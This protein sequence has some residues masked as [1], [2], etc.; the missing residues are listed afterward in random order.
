MFLYS[1][2]NKLDSL[3]I[4]SEKQSGEEK[5]NTLA[6]ISYQN[7]NIN[8]DTGLY[9]AEIALE[10][11]KL[12]KND[13]LKSKVLNYK[14]L[15]FIGKRNY[16]YSRK[17][18]KEALIFG[19][20]YENN[21]Q[22]GNSYGTLGIIY[23]I[24]NNFDSALFVFDKAQNYYIKSKSEKQLA[25]TYDNIGII[26]YL[27]GDFEKSLE[28]FWLAKNLFEKLNETILLAITYYKIGAVFSK[29]EKLTD[30][31]KYTLKSY[32]LLK[33][34]TKYAD[35]VRAL[36]TLGIISKDQKKF[37]TALNYYLDALEILKKQP[38]LYIEQSILTNIGLVYYSTK[39]YDKAIEYH[40]NSLEIA[41]K[42]GDKYNM[43]I[44]NNNIGIAL[45]DLKKYNHAEKYLLNSEKFFVEIQKKNELI[46]TYQKLYEIYK[47]QN[48]YKSAFEYIEKQSVLKDS[49]LHSQKTKSLDSLI[50]IFKTTELESENK[51]LAHE[52]ELKNKIIRIQKLFNF[53]AV[54]IVLLILFFV[55]II[56]KNKNTIKQSYQ[57]VKQKNHEITTY[58]EELKTTNE[59]LVELDQ[60]KAIT[61][62]MIVHDLKNPLNTIIN[63]FQDDILKQKHHII[64]NAG[65]KMKYMVSNILD[66][67]KYE[68]NKMIINLTDVKVIEAINCAID[69]VK[70]LL[71]DKNISIEN[72]II[73]NYIIRADLEI[74]NRVIVNLLCN[75]IKFSPLNDKIIINISEL[76]NFI[77][78]VI[79][80]NGCGIA[81]E[82]H[83]LIFEKF[84]QLEAKKQGSINSTGIGLTF[85]KLAIE[86]HNGKIG[87]ISDIGKGA[88]FWFDIPKSEK[89]S[90]EI[91]QNTKNQSIKQQ[92]IF[93]E[94]ELEILEPF[95][96]IISIIELY[97]V[98]EIRKLISQLPESSEN[99][100]NWKQVLLK[101]VMT[102]NQNLFNQLL[103]I[104]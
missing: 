92:F 74:L 52:T 4:L 18:I 76:P 27:K 13:E 84:R 8:P 22:L 103:Q 59:K 16:T 79:T 73:Q 35:I 86:S 65:N 33:N 77:R 25:K 19:E 64:I 63:Y 15:C 14:A 67:Q 58:S 102:Q 95:I 3:I 24:T 87:I 36:N 71:S 72:N 45:F 70:F 31:E 42:I 62:Q 60:F 37:D 66:I 96:E 91:I 29:T 49:L 101:S 38:N 43:A 39:N 34:T 23:Q 1:Q 32:E 46:K 17:I 61:M 6:E 82:Y 53:S 83:D 12:Q 30:A 2:N 100:N 68:D 26:Y 69:E 81:P 47:I 99:I 57:I 88:T 10:L 54:F 85:C 5:I 50:T 78:I 20:K 98:T 7:Y 94:S 93:T 104:L 40:K 97:K 75:A 90:V 89:Q 11:I 48:N 80:D 9:Y 28:Y 56:I 41:E 51:L 21:E 55:I 44:V